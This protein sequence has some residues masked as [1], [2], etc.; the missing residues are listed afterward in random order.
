MGPANAAMAQ[1]ILDRWEPLYPD[2]DARVNQSLCELLVYLGSTKVVQKTLPLLTTSATQ[3]EKFHYLFTLRGVS[4]GW[5]VDQRKEYFSWLG[6]ARREFQGAN[7]LP[8]A[9]NY[10]R[11]EAEATLRLEE[12]TTLADTLAALDNLPPSAPAPVVTRAFVREWSMAD[13]TANLAGMGGKRNPARGKRLYAETGC[14]QCHRVGQE[15]G[16]IGPELTSVSSRFDRRTLLES[17]I[18]PSRVVS[19]TY[20]SV[21]VA[22]KSGA[23]FDGRIVDE[24]ARSI[25]LA[26]NPVDPDQRRRLAKADISGQRVSEVSPMPAGLLNTLAREEILDLLAWIESGGDADHANFK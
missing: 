18:E 14:M 19:E 1:P 6:R 23:I 21:T 10:I 5:T 8:T 3:E 11:A 4:N 16:F 9:L 26:I 2:S 15:G 24:D 13:L 7:M 25:S 12:R 17:I 20:R 22:M